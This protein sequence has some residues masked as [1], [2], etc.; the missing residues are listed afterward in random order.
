M[1]RKF[2]MQILH[3]RADSANQRVVIVSLSAI[4]RQI[5]H[6]SRGRGHKQQPI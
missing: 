6:P 2:R 3:K 1:P 4:S 5:A